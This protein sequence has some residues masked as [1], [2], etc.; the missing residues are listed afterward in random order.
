MSFLTGFFSPTDYEKFPPCGMFTLSHLVALIIFLTIII[1]AVILTKGL[2]KRWIKRLTKIIALVLA[3]LEIGKIM[4]NVHY[5]YLNIDNIV[6]LHF[7]S[8][9]IYSCF[10]AGFGKGITEKFGSSYIAGAGIICGGF[11]LI[12]PTTSLTMHPIIHF[13]SIH[14]MIY[15]SLMVYLGIMYLITDVFEP[16]IKNFKYYLI[17]CFVFYVP[18]LIINTIYNS[19]L[20]F[21]REPYR[22]PIPFLAVVQ[23]NAQIVYTLIIMV[24]YLLTY[25]VPYVIYMIR[26]KAKKHEY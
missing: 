13:L 3:I 23:K 15:H 9:F 2:S 8:L 11:F 22:I 16:T 1:V 20:M 25:L 21:L 7:C 12:F 17:Y 4:Y 14:S 19:N 18:A 24:A 10:M 6:P 5:D 26:K